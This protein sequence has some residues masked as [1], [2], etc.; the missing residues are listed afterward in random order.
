M[1]EFYPDPEPSP[2]PSF[3][4]IDECPMKPSLIRGGAVAFVLSFFPFSLV[5][6][7]L[8][9]IVAALVGVHDYTKRYQVSLDIAKGMK[10]GVLCCMLGYGMELVVYDFVWF[11]FDYQ[12]GAETYQNVLRG[13][14][15][16]LPPE[17]IE[18]LGDKLDEL[19]ESIDQIAAQKFNV[20]VI[21]QQFFG[22]IL[23]SAIG[24]CIGGL[25][26]S[27]MFKKGPEAK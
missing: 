1:S 7:C 11:A 24:G 13:L 26:G 4:N 19:N 9:L 10:I 25:I 2:E 12:I 14:L 18:E 22:L 27:A 17:A 8:P 6:C 16:S 15:D 3:R 20:L 21:I 5:I 23:V